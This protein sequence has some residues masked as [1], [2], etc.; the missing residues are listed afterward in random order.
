MWKY[1]DKSHFVFLRLLI[2]VNSTWLIIS[3]LANQR[4]RKVLF[5]CVVL[6]LNKIIVHLTYH[7]CY[8]SRP[9]H[10]CLFWTKFRALISQS[11]CCSFN[12]MSKTALKWNRCHKSLLNPYL[13]DLMKLHL[14]VR[15][16]LFLAA[17]FVVVIQPLLR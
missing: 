7:V 11:I 8:K 2:E 10:F 14:K 1:S 5:T 6:I 15:C 9:W 16:T 17:A 4:V 13:S 12:I 3:E